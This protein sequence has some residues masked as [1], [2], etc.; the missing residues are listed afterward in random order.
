MPLQVPINVYL[1]CLPT[2]GDR[3]GTVLILGVRASTPPVL[4]TK[5]GFLPRPSG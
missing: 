4:L 2:G 5:T 3:S 1:T